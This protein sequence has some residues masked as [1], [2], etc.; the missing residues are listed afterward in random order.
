[1]QVS[2]ITSSAPMYSRS[3]KERRSMPQQERR[4]TVLDE[5]DI[6]APRVV[7]YA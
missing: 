5:R 7:V 2:P 4:V 6:N 3:R 1:M